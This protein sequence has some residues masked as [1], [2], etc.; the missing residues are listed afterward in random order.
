MK[1]VLEYLKPVIEDEKGEPSRKRILEILCITSGCICTITTCGWKYYHPELDV[2][3][4]TM[5]IAPLFA[6]GLGYAG[7]TSYYQNKTNNELSNNTT[8][9]GD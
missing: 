9:T 4:I 1:S 7:I 6:T 3:T 5:L 2:P 8:R